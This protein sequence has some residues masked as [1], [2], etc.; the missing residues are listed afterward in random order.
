[1]GY[2]LLQMLY[3]GTA[4]DNLNHMRNVTYM[5]LA[6]TSTK[7][8]R[9]ERL[10]PTERAANFLLLRVHLQVVQWLHLTKV[11]F[12]PENWGW[13]LENDHYVLITTDQ[14]VAPDD[15]LNVIK[16]QCNV[17]S[18]LPCSS[19]RFSCR[20]HGLQCVSACKHCYGELCENVVQVSPVFDEE[21]VD[22][23]NDGLEN[24]EF[25]MMAT[26]H[27]GNDLYFCDETELDLFDDAL[28]NT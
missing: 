9:P 27:N 20:A 28:V 5:H 19:S 16:C 12:D 3:G 10:P 17:L 1:V 21:F 13:K 11:S 25:V 18:N 26:D 7:R 24:D 15:V 2:K 8:P 6:V 23:H 4:R 14:I 22:D